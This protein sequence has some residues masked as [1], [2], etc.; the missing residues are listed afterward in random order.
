MKPKLIKCKKI[1]NLSFAKGILACLIC[2]NSTQLCHAQYLNPQSDSVTS[3]PEESILLMTGAMHWWE[4]SWIKF[5]KDCDY[6]RS[7]GAPPISETTIDL[8]QKKI[9]KAKRDLQECAVKMR[10]KNF[11]E[12]ELDSQKEMLFGENIALVNLIMSSSSVAPKSKNQLDSCEGVAMWASLYYE[13]LIKS[14]GYPRDGWC[15]RLIN[16]KK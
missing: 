3:S 13:S 1:F 12:S 10:G 4:K 15:S 16:S 2:V 7:Y 6:H 8:F 9:P 14:S 11:S 5:K